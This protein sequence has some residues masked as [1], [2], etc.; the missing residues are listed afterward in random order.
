MVLAQAYMALNLFIIVLILIVMCAILFVGT[1]FVTDS[2][3][4]INNVVSA[5]NVLRRIRKQREFLTLSDGCSQCHRMV[6]NGVLKAHIEACRRTLQHQPQRLMFR[7]ASSEFYRYEN[8]EL[9]CLSRVA[10]HRAAFW[11]CEYK[12]DPCK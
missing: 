5:Y 6:S 4:L 7:I 3:A 11:I 9:V 2:H 8:I 12:C 1:F 10:H